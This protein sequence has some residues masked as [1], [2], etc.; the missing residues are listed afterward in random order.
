VD[1]DYPPIKVVIADGDDNEEVPIEATDKGDGVSCSNMKKKVLQ[2]TT[3]DPAIQ[4]GMM[5]FNE[6]ADCAIDLPL[7]GYGLRTAQMHL[8]G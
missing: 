3:A 6:N 4:E 7:A 1:A 5:V 2:F 8:S